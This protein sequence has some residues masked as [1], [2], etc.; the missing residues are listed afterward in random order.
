MCVL[1]R[2]C[3]TCGHFYSNEHKILLGINCSWFAG[4]YKMKAYVFTV[5]SRNFT[6]QSESS[7]TPRKKSLHY[8]CVYWCPSVGGAA[9][10]TLDITLHHSRCY[11]SSGVLQT[12]SFKATIQASF[13]AGRKCFHQEKWGVKALSRW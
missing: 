6:S 1:K 2:Q 8:N 9:C 10:R 5:T 7:T 11:F 4:H 12:H 13:L 3:F